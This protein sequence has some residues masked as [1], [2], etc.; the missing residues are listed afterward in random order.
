MWQ[1]L[2]VICKNGRFWATMEGVNLKTFWAAQQ[3]FF[4]QLLCAFKV[5]HTIK[6]IKDALAND[7]SVIVGVQLTGD[8][9][10]QE[11]LKDLMRGREEEAAEEEELQKGKGSRRTKSAPKAAK[12]RGEGPGELED[13]FSS[14]KETF[15]R[16]IENCWSQTENIPVSDVRALRKGKTFVEVFGR[17]KSRKTGPGIGEAQARRHKIWKDLADRAEA[18]KFPVNPIDGIIQAFGPDQVAEVTGRRLR[19]ELRESGCVEYVPRASGVP[20]AK[21]NLSEQRAFVSGRKRVIIISQAGSS[22]ISL[23]AGFDYLNQQPRTH[24]ILELPWSSE[25]LIQQCGRSHRSNQMSAPE[26]IAISTDVAGET[27]FAMSVAARMQSL[28]R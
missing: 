7:R 17:P 21:L 10:V 14:T 2:I 24:I 16:L 5:K 23:H 12:K 8:S 3:L 13:A 19:A 9:R 15:S 11:M 28:A 1:R 25:Q 6:L 20:Q 4:R 18:L 26:F 22:G 27:R